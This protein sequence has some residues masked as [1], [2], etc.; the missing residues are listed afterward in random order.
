MVRVEM[1][2]Q[3]GN[4]TPSQR[5]KQPG[6]SLACRIS[7]RVA[8]FSFVARSPVAVSR[9]LGRIGFVF[10]LCVSIMYQRGRSSAWRTLI[11]YPQ[12]CL[13][14]SLKNPKNHPGKEVAAGGKSHVTSLPR[15]SVKNR[16]RP[17]VDNSS[18]VQENFA[19]LPNIWGVAETAS[20]ARS[21]A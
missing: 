17:V 5:M 21:F 13:R 16:M 10:P 20:L 7:F 15:S 9:R 12:P 18:L 19:A 4:R 2:R 8:A 14:A 6:A 1:A 3:M 11:V